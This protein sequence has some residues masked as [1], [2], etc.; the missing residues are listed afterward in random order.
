MVEH[1]DKLGRELGYPT[2][3]I[4]LGDYLR[5]RYG[6][7]AVRGR[8]PTAA[9]ST[10]PRISASGRASIRRRNCSK[11]YFFDFD[12]DLY[13]QTIEVELIDFIRAE[14]KF[15]SLDALTAQ[16]ADDATR[17]ALGLP[18]PANWDPSRLDDAASFLMLQQFA[19]RCPLKPRR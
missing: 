13:G 12:G 8:W 15:D 11:P 10:A 7:Y 16:M 17:R 2:A 3:N 14:A 9:C 1:G 6:I 19:C 18:S 4:D 5:P